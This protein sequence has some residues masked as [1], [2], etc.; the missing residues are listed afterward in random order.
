MSETSDLRNITKFDGQNFQLW[1]FQIKA[2]FVAYDL[3]NIVE[4]IEAKPEVPDDSRNIWIKKDA[5]AKFILSSSM[6]YSQ[7]EYLIT[8]NT[9]AEMWTKLS[10]IHEQKSASNKLALTTKFHEYRMASGDSI[11]QHIAKIENIANQLKDID[12]NLSDTMIMAKILGTLP[13]KYNAFVSAWDSV[14]ATEQTLPR[15]RERLIREEARMTSM[16]EVSSAL[17]T[18]SI[19]TDGKRSHRQPRNSDP[20]AHKKKTSC[21]FCKKTGH[22]SKFCFARKRA[23]KTDDKNDKSKKENDSKHDNSANFSAFVVDDTAKKMNNKFLA[24]TISQNATAVS[25]INEEHIWLLD[26]GAS[27]HLCCQ[28]E[29]FT[30]LLPCSNEYVYL[31]DNTR[32]KVEGRGKILISR[33]IGD[34][35]LDGEINNVSYIPCLKKNLFSTG[36]CTSNGYSITFNDNYAHILSK[37]K[38]IVACGIKQRNNLIRLLIEPKSKTTAHYASSASLKTWHERLGHVNCNSL[39]KLLTD[40]SVTGINLVNKK[41]F[42]CENCPL[43]KQARLPFASNKAKSD[44]VPGE[45]VHTDLCGPMQTPSI[46]GAKFFLLFKDEHSGFRTV[47]FLRHKNDVFDRLKEFLN[48]TKNQ[49]GKDIKILR[50]DNGTEFVNSD[51]RDLLKQRGIKLLTSS[52]HT[53]EQNGRAEREMRTIV[54]SARSMLLARNFPKN[55]WGEAVNTAIYVL[56]RTIPVHSGKTPIEIYMKKKPNLS[57]IRT[58]GCNAYMH[59]PDALRKKWDPKS[60]KKILVGY[61][62]DSDNYRLLDLHTKRITISRNVVFDENIVD[63]TEDKG[64]WISIDHDIEKSENEEIRYDANADNSSSNSDNFVDAINQSLDEATNELE[65]QHSDEQTRPGRYH[66]RTRE[67]LRAPERYTAYAASCDVPIT[68]EEA[69]NGENSISWKNAI[70]KELKAHEDNKTWEIVPLPE[71]RKPIGHKW[72]FKIKDSSN[73]NKIR[74]KA[75]LCA[76]GFSQQAGIDYDEIFSP[77]VR[78]ESIRLLLAISVKE[79]LKSIQFD[80]STA[81]LNSNLKETT[82]MRVPDGLIV[83]D[84]NLVL[85]LNKA[86]YGLKQSGRCWNEK[87]NLFIKNIGFSQCASDKCV[88]TANYEDDKVYLALYVDDGLIFARHIE[89]LQKLT[90]VLNK[91]FKITIDDSKRFVGME[92][93]HVNDGIFLSQ[94]NYIDKILRKFNMSEANTV[95]TPADP[96]VCLEKSDVSENHNVPY[97]EAVGSLLFLSMISRPDIA[98]SVSIVSRY[99]NN[100]NDT[101]WTAVKR[102]F[103]YIKSTKNFGILFSNNCNNELI[104]YSDADYAG[105]RD[106]RRSTTGYIFI[107]NGGCIAWSSKR[108]ATVSLSTTEAEFI[109]ASE[110]TKEAIWLRKLLSD[111]GHPCVGPTSLYVDNQSAIKLSRNPEFHPRSKH[112]DV[113]HQFICEKLRNNEIDTRYVKSDD[114]CADALTKPLCV[115]KFNELRSKLVTVL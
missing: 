29:W 75:R 35:W 28:K 14:V 56:N 105:D 68:Y 94:T 22:I 27:R 77:V 57:H 63:K 85:K 108:Q 66:L 113:R 12:E 99:L 20:A 83:K 82:Y 44:T 4:G 100:Y 70:E 96:H 112:I 91:N 30:D 24:R 106:T 23:L 109:A 3:L 81:Y 52:P 61:E 55:L 39:T 71:N 33:L 101:Y 72:V 46:G 8:C 19:S 92:I 2:I 21:S 37:D 93:Q 62:K 79:N 115:K 17:A 73:V 41:S 78:Y 38:Q 76:Q 95:N 97:R 87:F 47:Y 98:F 53:P 67:S 42:F 51:V 59:V 107:L 32:L 5:R 111:L 104:G 64:T 9:A 25:E 58:F 13:S 65:T 114:Q 69:V 74:Y 110:A 26:S 45:I 1:K 10:A 7:L 16:D 11:A 15:L 6:E 80:V 48:L 40:G 86:I 36:A 50:A 54:E 90:S 18:S 31:G 103:R 34:K 88:Y 89:T 102:I 84:K 49:F 43:G 60:R